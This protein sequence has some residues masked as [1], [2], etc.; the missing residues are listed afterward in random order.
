M[1]EEKPATGGEHSRPG[2]AKLAEAATRPPAGPLQTALDWRPDGSAALTAAP[3]A[4]NRFRNQ[5]RHQI[6]GDARR[7]A[8]YLASRGKLPAEVL[9]DVVSLGMV[10][11]I[12]LIAKE[13]GCTK[14]QALDRWQA[15]TEALLPFTAPRFETIE[16]GP[17]AATG[18]AMGHY[19]AAS[20]MSD[21]LANR[22]AAGPSQ[23]GITLDGTSQP[24]LALQD[25]DLAPSKKDDNGM[26]KAALPPKA[27]D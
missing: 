10:R 5:T 26:V 8:E 4:N 18:L 3:P 15:M 25:N 6:R 11:A 16:L 12:R 22:R 7:T 9:Q 2:L 24:G 17:T 19:L 23:D 27:P 1:D 13:T 21:L 14:L 20:A